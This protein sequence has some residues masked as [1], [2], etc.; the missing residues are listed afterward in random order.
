MLVPLTALNA[1]IT[2]STPPSKDLPLLDLPF[3]RLFACLDIPTIVVAVLGFLT[4]ERKVRIVLFCLVLFQSVLFGNIKYRLL[5]Q[6][7]QN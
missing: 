6:S 3:D 5:L 2:L 7:I 4:L 1:H